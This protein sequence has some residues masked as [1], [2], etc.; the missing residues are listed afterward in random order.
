MALGFAIPLT[1]SDFSADTYGHSMQHKHGGDVNRYLMHSM[2]HGGTKVLMQEKEKTECHMP[3][4]KRSKSPLGA[5]IIPP[6]GCIRP[7]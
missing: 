3:P 1:T 2:Y 4:R 7:V 5:V 6:T